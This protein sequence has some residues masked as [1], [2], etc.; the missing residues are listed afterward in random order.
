MTRSKYVV[1]SF[2]GQNKNII[3]KEDVLYFVQ[4]SEEKPFSHMS[5]GEELRATFVKYQ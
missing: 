3:D 1:C 5:K 4:W 2:V